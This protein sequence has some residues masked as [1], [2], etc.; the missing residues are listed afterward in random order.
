MSARLDFVIGEHDSLGFCRGRELGDVLREVCW[1][2]GLLFLMFGERIWIVSQRGLTGDLHWYLTPERSFQATQLGFDKR[3]IIAF[4]DLVPVEFRLPLLVLSV[5]TALWCLLAVFVSRFVGKGSVFWSSEAKLVALGLC[6]CPYLAQLDMH[7]W[8]QQV[9]LYFMLAGLLSMK[10]SNSAILLLLA[11]LFHELALVGIAAKF[12]AGILSSYSAR[13][14]V[15]VAFSGLIA[16]AFF[17]LAFPVPVSLP[18]PLASLLLLTLFSAVSVFLCF[19]LPKF[20]SWLA[21]LVSFLAVLIAIPIGMYLYGVALGPATSGRS[22]S[23][24]VTASL[25]GIYFVLMKVMQYRLRKPLGRYLL[26]GS[27][28]LL[29]LSYGAQFLV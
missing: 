3:G 1:W 17:F 16:S 28:V 29:N 14:G 22:I 2:L 11:S 4:I 20:E 7:L 13:F 24:G 12:L 23:L 19:F 10:L 18:N 6:L 26:V 25:L 15:L 27:G 8:R 21:S 5:T 9:S